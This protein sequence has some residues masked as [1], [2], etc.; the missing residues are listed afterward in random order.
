LGSTGSQAGATGAALGETG[1]TG[2]WQIAGLFASITGLD[3]LG[4]GGHMYDRTFR[5][6][7]VMITTTG[8]VVAWSAFLMFGKKRRDGDPPAPDEVLAAH[9][10]AADPAARAVDLVPHQRHLPP[11][12]DPSEA[13]MPRWRRPSLIQARKADPIRN[14][15]VVTSQTFERGVGGPDDGLERR[16]IRYR[17]VRLLDVPDELR[18]N[19]IGILDEG[20]EVALLETSG[21]YRLVRC[22]DGQQGWLHQMVLGDV[23]GGD[24]ERASFGLAPDGIDD[25]VLSAFLATRQKTA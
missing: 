14:P 22:P 20:D 19:E 11:G 2:G 5:A 21:T 1:G 8:V 15:A 16:R 23:V 7:P 13:S 10:A 25:D 3:L 17:V 4:V 12:V 6:I 18:A 9:A 24:N